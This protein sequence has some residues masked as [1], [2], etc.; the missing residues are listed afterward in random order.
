MPSPAESGQKAAP[1]VT[2]KDKVVLALSLL[3][4]GVIIGSVSCAGLIL[5]D[6]SVVPQ[7]S[8][9]LW[10]EVRPGVKS[11][12]SQAGHT[13]SW[14][15]VVKGLG[16]GCSTIDDHVIYGCGSLTD[17]F[18]RGKCTVDGV[19]RRARAQPH[20]SPFQSLTRFVFFD[21]LQ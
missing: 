15:L 13:G 20:V 21:P 16:E 6:R 7:V 2:G 19:R 12:S 18:R 1:A 11:L 4:R 5:W 10:M 17:L 9:L 8:S 3:K 14:G